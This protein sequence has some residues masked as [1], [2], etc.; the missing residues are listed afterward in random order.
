MKKLS[1]LI[2]ITLL[3]TLF[4][5]CSLNTAQYIRP[6][7]KP[8]VN[9]YT[10]EIKELISKN[11]EYKIKVFD[12]NIYKYYDVDKSEYDI[13]P[14]FIDT[15]NDEDYE[16]EIEKDSTPDYKLIIEFSDNKYV[17]NAYND[18]LLSIYPWDGVY[19]E[20]TI[21]MEG[22]SDYYNLYNFCEYIK[23]VASNEIKK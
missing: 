18:K 9:Y 14:E 8:K 1:K 15:L 16:A 3:T 12:M 20:D 17:I 4:I 5:G 10:E 7:T 23:K 21:S 2:F 13:I 6:G 19:K 22:V 11:Q